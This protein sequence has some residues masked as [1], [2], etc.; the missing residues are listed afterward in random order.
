MLLPNF[1]LPRISCGSSGNRK[2][3]KTIFIRFSIPMQS[4]KQYFPRK[5]K[6]LFVAIK[7]V[8]TNVTRRENVIHCSVR[9]YFCYKLQACSS[10]ILELSACRIAAKYYDK[11]SNYIIISAMRKSL[12]VFFIL[13]TIGT[14]DVENSFFS[15]KYLWF[16]PLIKC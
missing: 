2:T 7:T 13:S 9:I 14:W 4:L 10:E 11:I 8:M 5:S 12:K 15:C 3:L 1:L 6:Y 16:F